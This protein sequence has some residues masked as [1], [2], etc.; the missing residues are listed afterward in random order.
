[1]KWVLLV[2]G[3]AA[4]VAAMAVGDVTDLQSTATYVVYMTGAIV[5]LTGSLILAGT[6]W[7]Q[8]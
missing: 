6:E 5:M 8:L 7:R 3:I 2:L 1:M 4:L